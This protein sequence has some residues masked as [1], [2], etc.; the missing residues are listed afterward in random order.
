MYGYRR[1]RQNQQN[2]KNKPRERTREER[3][4]KFLHGLDSGYR[5]IHVTSRQKATLSDAQL[6]RKI[7]E[8]TPKIKTNK[9]L[10][11]IF[12]ALGFC[13]SFI[14]G[15]L[16][17]EIGRIM[18]ILFIGLSAS[19]GVKAAKYKRELKCVVSNNIVRGALAEK[20]DV[21]M[22]APGSHISSYDVRFSGLIQNWNKISGSDL[23]EGIYK[24]VKFHFSDIH[25]EHEKNS[26]KSK[27]RTT[28]FKG[29]W[30]IIDL[31]KEIPWFVELRHRGAIKAKS[32][33]E[34]EN[35]EFNRMFQI[36]TKDPHTAFYVLTP[37][38]IEYI[39]K[40]KRRANAE[41]YMKIIGKQIYIALHNGRDLFEPY[42]NNL[43]AEENI[44][45]LRMQMRWDVNYIS[46]IIDELLHNENLFG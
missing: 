16:H 37:H 14:L 33:V 28:R 13:L 4:N 15:V 27:S 26:G 39:I 42:G 23:I 44:E 43:F 46:G 19:F 1:Y 11:S 18:G 32:D 3:Y 40:A 36:I 7:K 34:T 35:I 38:F 17:G 6:E 8:L 9:A 10:C 21:E 20:F 5:D 30:L 31:K 45:T 29:Q 41:M 25:L 12:L 22:Y 24:G 2:Q